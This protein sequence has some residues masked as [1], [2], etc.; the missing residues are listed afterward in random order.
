MKQK[1]Y[2]QYT[3]KLL[4]LA[5]WLAILDRH[6]PL[7]GSENQQKIALGKVWISFCEKG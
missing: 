3:L 1:I 6:L 4:I 2:R 5:P 7:V